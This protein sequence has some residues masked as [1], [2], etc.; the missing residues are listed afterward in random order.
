MISKRQL[1]LSLCGMLLAACDGGGE[2][3]TP[4]APP[5]IAAA[6]LEKA[7]EAPK[8]P[9]PASIQETTFGLALEADPAYTEGKESKFRIVLTA[10][11]GYHVNQDYPI[12]V[13]LSGPESLRLDKR[14][15]GKPDAAAFGEEAARFEVPFSA[16][17]GTHEV[18]AVVDFAVCTKETCVPDQRTLA[19]N[20]QVM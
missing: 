16:Q 18:S 2:A 12:R 1:V 19:L 20:L 9:P 6:P 4:P 15:L 10:K 11:G 13:D 8:G 5:A 17:K 3:A 7:P 14:S